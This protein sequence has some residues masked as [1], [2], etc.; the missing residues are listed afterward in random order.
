MKDEMI[1]MLK[2]QIDGLNKQLE[3][4]TNELNQKNNLIDKLM[5]QQNELIKKSFTNN[6]QMVENVTTTQKYN[7]KPA[8]NLTKYLN[9][10]CKDAMNLSDFMSNYEKP[11]WEE[12][13]LLT[14]PGYEKLMIDQIE[15]RFKKLNKKQLPFVCSNQRD[16][17]IYIKENNEW[18]KYK[19][20]DKPNLL[21]KLKNRIDSI[22]MKEI[23]RIISCN[24]ECEDENGKKQIRRTTSSEKSAIKDKIYANGALN[25]LKEFKL[26]TFINGL[27]KLNLVEK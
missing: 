8:F 7:N 16:A 10:D 21:Y 24:D 3:N 4:V 12:L 20:E 23:S 17:T 26:E 13:T 2:G 6:I 18:I 27:C 9:E 15:K 22:I 14:S 25:S 1:E 5:E 19:P 11:D